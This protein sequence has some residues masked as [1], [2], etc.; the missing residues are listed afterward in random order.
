MESLNE[1]Q[2]VFIGITVETTVLFSD[3]GSSSKITHLCGGLESDSDEAN[4]Q[5]VIEDL[6]FEVKGSW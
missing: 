5:S 2:W 6:K 1:G 3:T 4:I